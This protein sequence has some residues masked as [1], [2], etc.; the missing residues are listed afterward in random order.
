VDVNRLQIDGWVKDVMNV[1]PPAEKYLAFGWNV[2]AI[3]GH[4][5]SQILDAF[6]ALAKPVDVPR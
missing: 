3:D 2:I 5:L 4:D 1:E 6:D